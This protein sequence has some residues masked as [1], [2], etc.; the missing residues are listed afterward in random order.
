MVKRM[1]SK[2][3]H[4]ISQKLLARKLRKSGFRT[5][6]AYNR[7]Y[8]PDVDQRAHRVEDF[9]CGYPYVYCFEDRGHHAY[10]LIY[11]HGPGG[12]KDAIDTISEWCKHT[13]KD[14]TRIDF[15]RVSKESWDTRWVVNE[16]G[17][18][19]YIFV[20]FKSERDYLWFLMKWS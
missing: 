9:Y 6:E 3:K 11:D 18:G 17:G 4:W 1:I 20:A 10:Q 15:H 12:Y 8:D 7:W 16:L 14:K 5:W 19:D 13:C 2:L